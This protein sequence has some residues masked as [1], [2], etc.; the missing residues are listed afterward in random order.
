MIIVDFMI[1]FDMLFLFFFIDLRDFLFLKLEIFEIIF[2][3][4]FLV[5]DI[6]YC[7]RNFIVFFFW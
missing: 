4:L 7:I 2:L 1:E 5:R 6:F 3:F